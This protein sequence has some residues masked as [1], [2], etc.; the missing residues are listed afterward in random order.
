MALTNAQLEARLNSILSQITDLKE[1]VQQLQTKVH[2]KAVGLVMDSVLKEIRGDVDSLEA[3]VSNLDRRVQ[4]L[5]DA[6]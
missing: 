3:S 4:D 1:V 5:E 2:A 6:S